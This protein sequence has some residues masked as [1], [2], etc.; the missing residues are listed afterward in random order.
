MSFDFRSTAFSLP[1]AAKSQSGDA[2]IEAPFGPVLRA[3]YVEGRD[4]PSGPGTPY[5]IS[6][7]DTFRGNIHEAYDQDWVRID[8]RAGQTVR[9]ALDGSGAG[10]LGDPYLMLYNARGQ[11]VGQDDDSGAGLNAMLQYYSSTGGTFYIAAGAYSSG[12]GQ[13]TIT[14]TNV[15]T[16]TPNQPFTM[17]EIAHQLTDGYWES[18][19]ASR[20]AF[21]VAPGGWLNADITGLTAAGQVLARAALN[22]WEQA[23]GIRF[24]INERGVTTHISFDDYDSGAY[25]SS[26]VMG[27]VIT[28]S[29]VNISTSWLSSYGTNFDSYS[30]QTYLHEIGHA[31]GLGHGGNYNGAATYGVDNHYAND[32]WQATLMSYF[33]QDQNSYVDASYAYTMTPMVAD[34]IAIRDLYGAGRLRMGDTVYGET[35]N[36]GG[37][38]ARISAMLRNPSKRDNITFTI[39]DDGGYDRLDLGS[40]TTN[41][42]IRLGGGSASNA[43]GLIGNILIARGTV[44]EEVQAGRGH[45]LVTGNAADNRLLGG[46]GNDTLIGG[47]GDDTLI[48]GAGNDRMVGGLGD[49]TYVLNGNDIIIEAAN[50]G[51]DTVMVSGR[52]YDLGANL[53]RLV[54]TGT[55]DLNGGGNALDNELHGNAGANLLHGYAGHD[56]LVGGG[57]NDTLNGGAGNDTLLGGVGNDLLIGDAGRDRLNGGAGDDTMRGGAGADVFIYTAGR[58]VIQDFQDNIDKIHLDD[59]LWG[60]RAM[61]AAQVVSTASVVNGDTV[62]DFGNGNSLRII[63]L[64]NAD[65]LINDLVIF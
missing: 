16:V 55:R 59:A 50:G 6:T 63:G 22:T 17:V 13:Y 42:V 60:N 28:S 30:Y 9:I 53:E 37:N 32:S 14:A 25:S 23:T 31:L 41:Q 5:A 11:L 44:I 47:L 57:G 7:G 12:T 21:D 19:G 45:D 10:A 46:L 38:Y 26:T 8:V 20:R 4:A 61:T 40:D 27:N 39:Q 1:H 2:L 56:R 15:R 29:F 43:Y 64:A 35:S 54:F 65:A 62:L 18:S 49:D 33:D 3:N 34:L 36:A 58:D 51:T 52:N 24:R 48:G